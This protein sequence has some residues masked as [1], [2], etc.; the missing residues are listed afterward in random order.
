MRHEMTSGPNGRLEESSRE[1]GMPTDR[2]TDLALESAHV[3]ELAGAD[4]R[5]FKEALNQIGSITEGVL[6]VQCC[7]DVLTFLLAHLQEIADARSYTADPIL[8]AELEYV[9][10]IGLV[11][12]RTSAVMGIASNPELVAGV[13][14]CLGVMARLTESLCYVCET[15]H[16]SLLE[17]CI[18]FCK[19]TCTVPD[20]VN[21]LAVDE[22]MVVEKSGLRRKRLA[23][24]LFLLEIWDCNICEL[25]ATDHHIREAYFELVESIHLETEYEVMFYFY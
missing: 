16:E 9:L 17:S 13:D 22:M 18:W 2:W 19:L 14:F 20:F 4:M 1:D 3:M 15:V 23:L 24:I 11:L 12:M 25:V 10:E 8:E 21:Q 5:G 6:P 7:N